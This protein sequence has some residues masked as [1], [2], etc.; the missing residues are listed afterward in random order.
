MYVLSSL[1][2]IV[3]ATI[4]LLLPKPFEIDVQEYQKA[5]ILGSVFLFSHSFYKSPLDANTS[6]YTP[7]PPHKLSGAQSVYSDVQYWLS[8]HFL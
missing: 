1:S 2:F 3:I 4:A 7:H 6:V 8:K 5:F